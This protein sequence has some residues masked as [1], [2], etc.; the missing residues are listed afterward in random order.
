MTTISSSVLE[1]QSFECMFR[2]LRK[3]L[4]C[5]RG[6]KVKEYT[7]ISICYFDMTFALFALHSLRTSIMS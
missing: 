5:T 4:T 3:T 1:A 7:V 2:A 6:I